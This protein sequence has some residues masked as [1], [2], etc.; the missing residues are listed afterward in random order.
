MKILKDSAEHTNC[1]VPTNI[2]EKIPI[3]ATRRAAI[4]LHIVGMFPKYV[5]GDICDPN[6]AGLVL[7]YLKTDVRNQNTRWND[8]S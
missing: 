8:E 1:K 5:L 3:A 6:F 4:S 2:W 7:G